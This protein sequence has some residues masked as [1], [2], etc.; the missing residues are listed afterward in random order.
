MLHSLIRPSWQTNT[1]ITYQHR[2]FRQTTFECEREKMAEKECGGWHG[3]GDDDDGGGSGGKS[4]GTGT[5]KSYMKRT[6]P[7]YSI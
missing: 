4:D 7:T 3:G 5:G 2:H 1:K 6:L